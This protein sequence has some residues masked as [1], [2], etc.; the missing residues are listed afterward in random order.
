MDNIARLIFEK[1][2]SGK[3]DKEA[4]LD[5]LKA[6][7]HEG[8]KSYKD[9]AIIG[10]SIR[11][12]NA[13]NLEQYWDNIRNRTE[14]IREFPEERQQDCKQFIM[15]FTNLNE[16]DIKFSYGGFLDE[17]DQFDY[18]FFNLSPN[19]AS[20]MDPNQRLFLEASWQA[21][22]DAGYGGSKLAGSRTGVYLG[23]ADWPVYGQYITQKQPSMLS[24]ASAGN[25]PS[26]IASRIS[27]LLDL[28]GP[29]F[30]VDTACSSSLVA[31]HLACTALKNDDCDLAIAGGV[32]VC[33]MPVDGVFEMGIE[34]SHKKTSA[35]DDSS[36]GTV[37][38]EGTV[39]LLLK[40]LERAVMD[41][42]NI[43]AVI[44]GSAINQ[45]GASVGIT[46]PNAAAQEKVLVKAWEDAGIDPETISYIEAHGTGTKLGDPIEINGIQRA[47]RRF[48]A[49]K[50]FCAI[51][52]VKTNIGHLDSTSGIAGLAKA[53]AALKYKELLPTLNFSR[54]NRKIAFESSPVYVNDRLR[55]WEK[56]DYPRRC[57]VSSFGFSGTNCHVVLEEA[58]A[59]KSRK[60]N[61]VDA[62]YQA[63]VLSAKSRGAL[64]ELVKVYLEYI[65]ITEA[66]LSDICFT[67]STGRGHYSYRLSVMALNKMELLEK[68]NS[69]SKA[70]LDTINY[71]GVGFGEHHVVTVQRENKQKGELTTEARR[72]LSENAVGLVEQF[73][74][75]NRSSAEKLKELCSL[76]VKGADINWGQLYEDEKRRRV[77]VPL[78]PFQRTRCWIDIKLNDPVEEHIRSNKAEI[79]SSALSRNEAQMGS[80]LLKGR[81]NNRYTELETKLGHVWGHLLGLQEID[82]YDDFFEIGGNSIQ[83]IKMEVDLEQYGIRISSN[84][85]YTFKCIKE[86][87]EYLGDGKLNAPADAESVTRS[88]VAVVLADNSVEQALGNSDIKILHPITPFNDVFYKNCFY[89]SMFPIVTHF[90]ESIMPFLL[91]DLIQY[92][93][94]DKKCSVQYA[95]VNSI[96]LI[97]EQAG[98][99]VDRRVNS[100]DIVNELI[101][102]IAE[103]KPVVLW[104]DAYYESIRKDTYLKQHVD[105]T[106]LIYGYNLE[107]KL[108]H[109]VEHER[110][111][112][113]SYKNCSIP[114]ADIS[115]GL[116][117]FVDH[118]SNDGKAPTHY[119]FQHAK[120]RTSSQNSAHN[121]DEYLKLLA[122]NML[123]NK[124]ITERSMKALHC[125]IED[126]R[127]ISS[128]EASLKEHI[129]YLV[130]F[131]NEVMNAKNIE[132]YRLSKLLEEKG[133]ILELLGD[134]ISKWDFVRKGIVRFM[135][136][137][138][139]QSGSFV[140]A[141]EKLLDISADENRFNELLQIKLQSYS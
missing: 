21:I 14:S 138:V 78:Y 15:N 82:I 59:I 65:R 41:N 20:L 36:D 22:E 100:D 5:V 115:Q 128:S 93:Y 62:S 101:Q 34:S 91:N 6:L 76:Y 70:D 103:E 69:V 39:A 48:T 28:Q 114:F 121:K 58:P 127:E 47:F 67:A 118:F 74:E 13:R 27:Y 132:K 87:A 80:I 71:D 75:S 10:V 46:A 135:Y 123:A 96:E 81:E 2:S 85:L 16:K 131:L 26:L 30:L 124:N 19:E 54:P 61:A 32:K 72:G 9:V 122:I 11:M 95:A 49:K 50:Q 40:P 116:Q 107:E 60:A 130:S 120:Q 44:K 139:Y 37:W 141:Y 99:R 102:C 126:F 4:G 125:F 83:T 133:E 94:K 29:A 33:L 3:M 45:D 104:V 64:E 73:V 31:V 53:I 63:L 117:G 105:H 52:S 129:D 66:D 134:L 77:E 38:G 92:E 84:E 86:L 111:E 8:K 17:V 90:E 110:R 98:L 1:V 79:G 25:T 97:F 55:K 56:E 88:E 12:P 42:D 24:V 109:I 136:M 113:L 106:L 68:L 119:I 140:L 57:G 43:Y 51:G 89:N 18:S 137:P 108:F 23:Y 35:F 112:N 7:K